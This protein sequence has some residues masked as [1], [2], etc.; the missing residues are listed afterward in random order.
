MEDWTGLTRKLEYYLRLKTFPVAFK[1]L[2]DKAELAANPWVRPLEGK[3]TLCQLITKVRTFDWTV[4]ATAQDLA[5]PQCASVI[6]LAELPPF[7][8]DGT[9]RSLV[10]CKTIEEAQKC[11]AAIP[12]IPTGTYEA[13]LMAPLVYKPFDPDLILIYA[14]AAQMALLINAIQFDRYERLTFFSVGETSCSDV[15]AQGWLSQKPALSIPCYGERRFGHAQDDELAMSL[16]PGELN[17]VVENLAALYQRGVRYPVSALGAAVDPTPAL[18]QV[19]GEK[20][21]G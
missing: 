12:R 3:N 11:E 14:N 21:K 13:V 19:Y 15:I 1:L 17:R 8:K 4:G 16:P 2:K 9:M 18:M 10:W 20:V 6:G 5:T 7:V